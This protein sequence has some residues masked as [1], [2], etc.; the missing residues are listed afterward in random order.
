MLSYCSKLQSIDLSN[1]DTTS[2]KDMKCMLKYNS[3]LTYINLKSFT[4]NSNTAIDDMLLG[5]T[6]A[7]I[8]IG[9]TASIFQRKYP[10]IVS[11]YSDE[12]F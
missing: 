5:I 9:E 12:C 10:D 1:F 7:K 11:Q 2:A 8:C 3:K 6:N 4:V